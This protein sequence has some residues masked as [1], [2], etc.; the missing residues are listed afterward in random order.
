[1][2]HSACVSAVNAA[3]VLTK[4]ID[5]GMPDTEALEGLNLLS[6]E[7]IDFDLQLAV[8]AAALRRPTKRKGLSLGDRCC[9][10]L[11][12]GYEVVTAEREWVKLNLCRVLLIR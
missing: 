10:G 1:M 5:A 8:Q 2:S 4:L 6:L 3:E 9:L 11:A 7:V 12:T